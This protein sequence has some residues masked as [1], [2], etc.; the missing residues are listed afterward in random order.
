[1]K[2]RETIVSYVQLYYE[3]VMTAQASSVES[4]SLRDG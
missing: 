2:E 1:M 3:F 4:D